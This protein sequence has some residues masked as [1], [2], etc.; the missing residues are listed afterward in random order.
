VLSEITEMLAR[1]CSFFVYPF[2]F[3]SFR[4]LACAYFHDV[5]FLNSAKIAEPPQTASGSLPE[6]TQLTL[7][8][9]TGLRSEQK[10]RETDSERE[11]EIEREVM[12]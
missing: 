1:S 7:A 6:L 2:V 12:K 4:F 3:L 9:S 11:G 8:V 10:N 5:R